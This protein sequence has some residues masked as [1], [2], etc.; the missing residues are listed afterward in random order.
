VL[1][2]LVAGLLVGVLA[3][4]PGCGG[5]GD[6]G[7]G[8]EETDVEALLDRA[9]RQPF[10][11]ADVEIDARLELD[12]VK[13]LDRPLRLQASGPYVTR[14]DTLPRFDLDLRVGAE[15]AGQAVESGF[16]ST[17]TRTYLKFGGQFYEQPR[18]LVARTNRRL[19]RR[20]GSQRG[21]LRELGLNPRAWVVDVT[22]EGDETVAG[23][24]ARHVSGRLAVRRVLA[25]LNRLVERAGG[26][27]GGIPSGV[28][29]PLD[30]DELNMIARAIEDPR[31]DVYVGRED[32][33]IRRISGSLRVSVP[34][35]DRSPDGLRGGS[36]RF[37]IELSRVNGDQRVDAPSRSRPF[38]DLTK[39]LGGALGS[40]GAGTSEGQESDS[41]TATAPSE[42]RYG[43][44]VDRAR[45]DDT[46]AIQRCSR[47][48]R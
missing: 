12:G 19:G 22:S 44:C 8:R 27:I 13:G 32:N 5:E 34:E 41:G 1:R 48:L 16:L 28:P 42:Q 18:R 15:G 6:D 3:A 20:G 26:A 43:E 17:G 24:K 25:D 30:S 4:A 7:G 47:L 39:Q 31:F 46:A 23:V 14:E 11:S 29:P 9:F 2:R 33:V 37:S 21:A 40:L 45:P 36:L 10:D 38:S 35:E